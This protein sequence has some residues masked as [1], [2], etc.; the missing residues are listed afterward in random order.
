MVTTLN[1]ILA[2]EDDL[3]YHYSKYGWSDGRR[4]IILLQT[5]KCRLCGWEELINVGYCPQDINSRATPV[6]Y[7]FRKR[8]EGFYINYTTGIYCPGFPGKYCSGFISLPDKW[9]PG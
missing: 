3:L 5:F 7:V 2:K 1:D 6:G 9:R 4:L 8:E